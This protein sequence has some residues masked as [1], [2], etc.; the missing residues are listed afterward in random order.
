MMFAL[1]IIPLP[2]PGD[3]KIADIRDET[4]AATKMLD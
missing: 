4:D 2:F 3:W 1:R